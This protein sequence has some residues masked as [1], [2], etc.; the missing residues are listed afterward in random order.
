[1]RPATGIASNAA[2]AVSSIGL[3]VR[4]SRAI[5]QSRSRYESKPHCWGDAGNGCTCRRRNLVNG[6]QGAD[7]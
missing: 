6:N 7:A 3:A 5:A 4:R 1:M 2:L